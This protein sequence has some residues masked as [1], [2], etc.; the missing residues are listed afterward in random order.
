M[1]EGVPIQVI[2]AAFNTEEGASQALAKLKELAATDKELFGIRNAA[3]LRRDDDNKLRIKET[4]D[5]RTGKG[6]LIGG[7]VGGVVGLLAG[8][9]GWAAL[10]GAAI[11]GLATRLRDSGFSDERLRQIGESLTPGTSAL[12]AEVEHRWVA[13]VERRL[14]EEGANVMTEAVKADVAAQLEQQAAAPKAEK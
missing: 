4:H 11:G 8:P 9:V 13:Q 6:A 14:A 1:D 7:V 12:I 3:V 10:G 2:V 5:M